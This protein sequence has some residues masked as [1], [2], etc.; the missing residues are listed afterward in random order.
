MPEPGSPTRPPMIYKDLHLDPFQEEAINALERGASV[1]ISAPTGAGKTLVAEYAI[2]K[3]IRENKKIIYTAP[4]K[5]LS[6]QKFRDFTKAYP[7]KVGIKTGDV[8]INVDAPVLLMTTEIFRNTIFDAGEAL[9]DVDYAILDEIH[10]LDD[11]E[12]GTVWEECIIFAPENVKLLCLSATVPNLNKLA[13]WIR[14]VRPDTP[15]EIILERKRPVPL[16]HSVF[17]PGLGVKR[18][19]E[20]EKLERQEKGALRVKH[21]EHWVPRMVEYLKEN[22]RLPCIF[23]A[24]NR[25]E[26]ERLAEN[27]AIELLAKPERRH[28][29]DMYDALCEQFGIQEDETAGFLRHLLAKGAC[30][31]HAG[32][33]PT[34]KE[35]I[36]RIFSTGLLK[37]L[38]ATE[39]FAVGVNM[40]AR[41][42]VFSSIF[43]FD[44]RRLNFIKTR[45]HHQMSGR[46]GR[47]GIDKV[48]YAYTVVEWPEV[49]VQAVRRVIFGQI[50]PIHSQFNLS[51]STILTLYSHIRGRIFQACEKSLANFLGGSGKHSDFRRKLD[52]LRKK[53]NLLRSLGYIEKEQITQKGRFAMKIYGY[54]LP[55]TELYF[56]GLLDRL[57]EDELNVLMCA[58]IYESK[59][60]CFHR[61]REDQRLKWIKKRAGR[62]VDAIVYREHDLGIEDPTKPLDFKLA[63][64]TH[65]WSRGCAFS[66]L[67]RYT[68]ADP[69]DIVRAFRMLIQLL[70]NAAGAVDNPALKE[71]LRRCVS[72]INRDEVNAERQLRLG[73][74]L[75]LEEETPPDEPP[76]LAR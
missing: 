67:E 16:E 33:L 4:I 57:N 39:T 76:V 42:V 73:A 48:G 40:P 27:V 17:V 46:A 35:I 25:K 60:G 59:R 69:G 20:L 37:L 29:L 70:R 32:L 31:H 2:E 74:E 10:Y 12:R 6:N 44:G 65:A 51:Y 19:E 61:H 62:A 3:C 54:E 11:I 34:L 56:S 43:K 52:Q 71:K 55:L 75:P 28:I 47:R 72:K 18:L 58:I 36:E 1:L 30:F 22:D 50:E 45:E 64:A 5:A 24:F 7:G 26:C 13:D 23:F 49:P 8:S 9:N 63:S 68:S 15:L 38:F 14:K 41:S 53:L 21:D 66:E